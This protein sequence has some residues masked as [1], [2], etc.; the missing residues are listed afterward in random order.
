MM[1]LA[2]SM[3]FYGFL[4]FFGPCL[5]EVMAKL[6]DKKSE[7]V[8]P[9]CKKCGYPGHFTYQCRNYF[10]INPN[11]QDMMLDVSSTSSESDLDEELIKNE[12]EQKQLTEDLRALASL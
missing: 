7:A 6:L 4:I 12:M 11:Q 9:G 8:R 2:F 3:D 1:V 10:K 5:A